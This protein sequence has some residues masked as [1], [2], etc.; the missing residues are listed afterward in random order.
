MLW[1]VAIHSLWW[2]V[3]TPSFWYPYFFLSLSLSKYTHTHIYIYIYIYTH[4]HTYYTYTIDLQ[5]TQSIYTSIKMRWP[6]SSSK[7]SGVT[8][9]PFSLGRVMPPAWRGGLGFASIWQRRFRYIM[10]ISCMHGHMVCICVWRRRWPSLLLDTS[11]THVYTY[12]YIYIH[13]HI[14]IPHVQNMYTK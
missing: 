7:W 5:S 9:M 2:A 14:Y 8:I 3:A 13:I 11:Y 4:I 6:H 12:I 10:N 1:E